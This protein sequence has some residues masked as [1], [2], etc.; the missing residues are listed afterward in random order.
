VPG[1]QICEHMPMQ[2][3]MFDKLA[4]IRSIISVDE[5]SDSLVM[6]GF[7]EAQNITAHR[8][9]F[10]AVVSKVRGSS[11][12]VPPYVSLYGMSRGT[13]PGYLGVA[14][15]TFKPYD[16]GEADMRWQDG[17]GLDGRVIRQE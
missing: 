12:D 8:P 15:R 1:I 13:E 3:R 4:T 2:A 17:S 16:T 5:H 6:T 11:A 9:S 10:G 14:H 7:P